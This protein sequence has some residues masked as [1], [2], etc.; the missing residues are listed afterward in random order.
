MKNYEQEIMK[1]IVKINELNF[2]FYNLII[3]MP[4]SF[5]VFNFVSI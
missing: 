2:L 1:T 3:I 5:L 4:N